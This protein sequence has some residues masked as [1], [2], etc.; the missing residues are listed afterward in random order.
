MKRT[1]RVAVRFLVCC[2]LILLAWGSG[3]MAD[4]KLDLWVS[5]TGI[6]TVDAIRVMEI[7]GQA[8]LFLP[9]NTDLS[10][11][12]IGHKAKRVTVN[13]REIG[14]GDSA[15]V[16]KAE[17]MT[18]GYLQ[19]GMARELPL[20]VLYGS[21]LPAMYITTQ[22][23]G[24]SRIHWDKSRKEKGRMILRDRDGS[25]LFE[26]RLQH[27]KMRG[28]ASVLYDK[29]NYAIKLEEGAGLLGMGK[30]KK[31]I[32]LGNHLDKSLLRNQFNFDMARYAGLMYT[33]DCRQIS[34]YVNNGYL[35]MYL[36]TEKVEIDDDR[37]AI[38]D[39][40]KET[41]SLNTRSLDTYPTAGTRYINRGRYRG[42]K[43]PVNPEDISGGYLLEFEHLATAYTTTP[44]AYYTKHGMLLI[45][46][47]PE[48][49]S[50]EQMKYITGLMQGFE[51]AIYAADGRDPETG[52]HYGE[53]VDFDSL[54]N[55]YLINEV[56]KNYDANMSSEYFFKPENAV[57]DKV[58]AGPVWDLDNTWGD[59]TRS[60]NPA[61]LKPENLFA[62]R[63]GGQDYWWPALYRQPDFLAAVVKRYHEVFVPALEILLGQREESDTLKSL[64]TYAAAVEKSVAME[65]VLY[66]Q[67]RWKQGLIQTGMNLEEN[68]AYLK[69]YITLRMAFLNETWQTDEGGEKTE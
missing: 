39:L 55:K 64:D 42:K 65:Y 60:G 16:L 45:I 12:R 13:G 46:H 38:R 29:K 9:G 52:K 17:E 49:C 41:E 57:S 31:W 14:S 3:A 8:Y 48:Y 11:Y 40:E 61:F 33:P 32:L 5:P 26:G 25:E 50:D 1:G 10:Q 53:F 4:N 23:G 7:Q 63:Q 43:I 30:A 2:L 36:L 37:V 20:K 24:L 66:P 69:N 47:E 54:V 15:E 62:C 19:G 34:L 21:D 6:L 28:N 22:S 18:L 58:F 27:M 51:N 56:S 68:I 35:G 59:Y 44:S 67:L